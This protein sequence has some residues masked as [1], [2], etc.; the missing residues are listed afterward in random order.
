L[1]FSFGHCIASCFFLRFTSLI[2]LLVSSNLYWD[3]DLHCITWLQVYFH[4]VPEQHSFLRNRIGD[5]MVSVLA[6]SAVGCGFEQRWGK[7]KDNNCWFHARHSL[8]KETAKTG[9]ARNQNIVSGRGDRSI[10]GLLFQWA[11]IS[12]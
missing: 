10:Y 6:S 2:G 9:C 8:L 7:N 11:S 3:K 12:N 4:Y 1:P 5:A